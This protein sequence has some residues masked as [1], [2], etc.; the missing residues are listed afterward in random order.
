MVAVWLTL[1]ARRELA[2]D[3]DDEAELTAAMACLDEVVYL[4]RSLPADEPGSWFDSL[5]E[6]EQMAESICCHLR[7]EASAL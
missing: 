1:A 3:D 6:I 7:G 5:A 4:A 2:Q